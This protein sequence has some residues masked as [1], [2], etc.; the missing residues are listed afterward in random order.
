MTFL[1]IVINA[2]QSCV[3][4]ENCFIT[5]KL[6]KTIRSLAPGCPSPPTRRSTL[7]HACSC[8]PRTAQPK[9]RRPQ[10]PQWHCGLVMQQ[11]RSWPRV[12]SGC[13][14]QDRRDEGLFEKAHEL[15]DYWANAAHRLRGKRHVI[16]D[17]NIGPDCW[18]RTRT[19]PSAPTKRAIDLF[20]AC[21][22]NGLLVKATRGIIALSPPL[23]L[24]K[25]HID[26]MFE[27]IRALLERI[28]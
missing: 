16:D 3:D 8:P 11:R 7:T 26:Q 12:H 21:F 25:Q 27:K 24:E 17:C 22:D 13:D 23:I 9:C 10:H 1:L 20:H 2:S 18:H 28:G 5:A 4:S 14:C 15:G 19:P 6:L